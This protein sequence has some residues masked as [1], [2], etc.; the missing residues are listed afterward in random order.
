MKKKETI[1]E[2]IKP[3]VDPYGALRDYVVHLNGEEVVVKAHSTRESVRLAK[4]KKGVK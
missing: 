1:K 2:V 4:E 3:A